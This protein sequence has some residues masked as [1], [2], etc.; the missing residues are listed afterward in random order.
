MVLIVTVSLTA[1]LLVSC[2]T[3]TVMSS[4]STGEQGDGKEVL[5]EDTMVENWQQNWFLDGLKATLEHRDGG[6]DFL[7]EYTV[8]KRVDRAGFDSQHAVLWTRDSF[9]GDIRITYTYTVLPGSSWQKLI[10]VQAQ[11]V[12][13]GPYVEDIHAWK[14]DREVAV[15]SDYFKYMDLIGLSLRNEIRCKRYPWMDMDGNDLETEFMPRAENKGLTEGVPLEV[16]V[17]KQKDAILLRILNTE[18]DVFSVDH[19]WDLT[20]EDVLKDRD[21]KFIEKG[22][23]GL[24]LMGGHKINFRDF[25]IERL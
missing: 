3:V 12:G 14:D 10:Y 25:K 13:E 7:T 16:T 20:D 2:N 1:A 18:T 6:L 23:I 24:R 17:E 22:R 4:N 11:G 9:E 8:N 21:P 5:F 15:M 19:R